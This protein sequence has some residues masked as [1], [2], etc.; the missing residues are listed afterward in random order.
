MEPAPRAA[1]VDRA[2]VQ[3]SSLRLQSDVVE[4]QQ[5]AAAWFRSVLRLPE[6]LKHNCVA[7]IVL[8]PSPP[9]ISPVFSRT[10]PCARAKSRPALTVATCLC[11]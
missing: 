11:G 2:Q 7:E 1:K 4:E 3:R 6:D 8:S 5:Q 10:P 9:M